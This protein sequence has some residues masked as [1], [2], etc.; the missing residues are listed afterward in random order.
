MTDSDDP[1]LTLYDGAQ[2]SG[3]SIPELWLRYVEVGG[4]AET[5]ELEAYV[6]GLLQPD[7]YQHNMIAQAVNEHFIE[8]GQDHPVG[9]RNIDA[10]P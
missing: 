5:I 2:L 7:D 4:N 8:Q 6:V 1:D 10:L 9:Y 3:M